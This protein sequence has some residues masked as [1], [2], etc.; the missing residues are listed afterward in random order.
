[1][2][3]WRGLPWWARVGVALVI[4]LS[5]TI[6]FAFGYIWTWRIS[7]VGWAVGL[8]MLFFAFPSDPEKKGYH[9]F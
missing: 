1:M 9:D 7:A 2:N 5:S 8:V 4:L 6:L 3:T